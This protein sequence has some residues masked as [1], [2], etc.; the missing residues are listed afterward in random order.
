MTKHVLEL[1]KNDGT[2]GFVE[3]DFKEIS[4]AANWAFLL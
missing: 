1:I 2:S 3:D 4:D